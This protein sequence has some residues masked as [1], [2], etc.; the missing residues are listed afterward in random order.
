VVRRWVG[1]SANLRVLDQGAAVDAAAIFWVRRRLGIFAGIGGGH[2]AFS[3][4][5]RTFDTVGGN[6]G[7]ECWFSPRWAL[8]LS[9]APNWQ[10]RDNGYSM[11]QHLLTLT[12]L[13]RP[14]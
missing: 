2:G 8:S 1:L 11:V 7:I 9:Y 5:P 4:S 6:A 12:L 3:D 13:A 10:Q 14:Y